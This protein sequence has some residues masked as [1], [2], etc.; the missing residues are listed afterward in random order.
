[1][2]SDQERLSDVYVDFYRHLYIAEPITPAHEAAM[3]AF[4][5][6]I[7]GRF[8]ESAQAS[9]SKSLERAELQQAAEAMAEGKSP[10]LDGIAIQFFTKYWDFIGEEFT[11][12]LQLAYATGSLLSQMNKGLIT[13]LHKGGEHEDLRNW[14]PITFLSVAYKVLAK[15]LQRRLQYILPNI[16]SEDQSVLLPL[17]YIL[18]NVL[19][20]HETIQWARETGQDLVLLKLD[21]KKAYNMVSLPFLFQVMAALGLL[22]SF[23]S[24]IRLLFTDAAAT[25]HI[26]G[27]ATAMFPIQCSV[28]QG[29]P[30]ALYLF[31][32][33]GEALNIA[34]ERAMDQGTLE[35]I[36]L[37][38]DE[39]QQFI[40]QYADDTS[41]TIHGTE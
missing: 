8:S 3:Q 27:K 33:I 41:Y 37:P 10:S 17:R 1:V 38:E 35:G 28:R 11:A 24:W 22:D 18:D 14:R 30:L 19:V 6:L 21:F 5:N 13:L 23:A 12:M 20:T 36:H 26:N 9:L 40:L 32:F 2:V 25:V 16:I 39:G 29:C 7:P 31:L 4:V 34:T 15:A